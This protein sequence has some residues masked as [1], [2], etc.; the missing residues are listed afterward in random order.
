MEERSFGRRGVLVVDDDAVIRE[1][2]RRILDGAGFPVEVFGRG[3]QAVERLQQEAFDLVISDLKMP[4]MSG[5]EVLKTIRVLQPEVPII[6]ITGYSTVDTAVEVMKNGAVD[7]LPKPFT[8]EQLLGKVV[9]A[10]Q[11]RSVD[12][13]EIAPPLHDEQGFAPFVGTSPAMQKVY[14]RIVQVAG[15]DSTVL[16]TGESGTGKELVA[17]AIHR[18]SPRRDQPF[19]AVDCTALVENLLESELFGHVKGSFTG[20]VQNKTG[21]FKVADSGT[22][23]LDEIAN[24]TL[25]TQAKLLRVLQERTVTPI[26]GTKPL[27]IDIHLLAATNRDLHSMV[28]KGEFRDD[29]FFRLNIIPVELP[30]LRQRQGDLRLLIGHFLKKFALATGKPIR[31][32]DPAAIAMLEDYAFPGNVREL[33]NLIERAVVLA[34]GEVIEKED[35]ELQGVGEG[36]TGARRVP[37]TAEEL[38]TVK[39]ML[40]ERAVEPVERAFLL[41]ALGRND[42]NV[43]RAAENVGM[44]RSNFQALL[45]KQGLSGRFHDEG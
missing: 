31:A 24:L 33:E 36:E 1:G 40:R 35:L 16:I 29:L 19:V 6:I 14:R 27:P 26:G 32:M 2:L 3:E 30:P 8:P 39:Q 10:L 9:P 7:Y 17:R 34:R 13:D 38:K 45:K 25:T 21:L 43:T 42:W 20:A 5:M 11:R 22:L 18:H 44:Q 41:D 28:D 37:Q 15:T 4:G 23:F 12:I